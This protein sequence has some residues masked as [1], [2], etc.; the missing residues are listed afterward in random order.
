MGKKGAP[1]TAWKQPTLAAT[2]GVAEPRGVYRT[3]RAKGAPRVTRKPVVVDLF[4]GLGG[5]TEGC[6]QA[7]FETVLAIDS[8]MRL[9][10][11]H[12]RN[13]PRCTHTAM[14]LGPDTEEDL[15]SMIRAHVPEGQPYH[16]HGSPPCQQLTASAAMRG[17]RSLAKGLRLVDWYLRLVARLRPWSW[18]MEEVAHPRVHRALA[19][20]RARDPKLVAY[21]PAVH[22]SEYGVP[23]TRRRCIAGT[24]RVV[25]R[26]VSDARLRARA[27][28]IREVLTPPEGATLMMTSLGKPP[29]PD[30]TVRTAD[31]AFVSH[32]GEKFTRT[33]DQVAWTCVAQHTHR[34]CSPDFQGIRVL[35]AHEHLLLQAFPPSYRIG[36]GATLPNLGIG[37]A[38]PPLFAKKFMSCV[39]APKQ[40]AAH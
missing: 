16:L 27:P 29:D 6:R 19:E 22:L 15:V 5:W 39:R 12:E 25:E 10:K 36:K 37:N 9:L 23:Q 40:N 31:G 8:N 21:V 34:W 14:T 3:L 33:L 7:G 32:E 1:G 20:A 18:S 30:L 4:C 2:L 13:H 38:V 17:E 24:P 28:T 11:I 35:T 26:L